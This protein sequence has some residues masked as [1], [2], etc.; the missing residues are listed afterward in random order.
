M[1][2]RLRGRGK[3]WW[4][5]G[6]GPPKRNRGLCL[7][8]PK[9]PY[10]GAAGAAAFFARRLAGF[11]AALRAGFFVAFFT[12]FRF[13]AFFAAGL[14]PGFFAAALRAGFFVAALRT[15]D[16]FATFLRAGFLFAVIGIETTPSRVRSAQHAPPKN[17]R[18]YAEG[19]LMKQYHTPVTQNRCQAQNQKTQ[20]NIAFY[21]IVRVRTKICS[22]ALTTGPNCKNGQKRTNHPSS[23]SPSRRRKMAFTVCG[24]AFPP[25]A[26]IT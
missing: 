2:R 18:K 23:G 9:A 15:V 6:R 1:E 22:N 12:T 16:F 10:I 21:C 19:A 7:H 17:V 11:F 4:R 26:F 5:A 13:A 8:H 24:L 25:V 14:R 3:I 20:L